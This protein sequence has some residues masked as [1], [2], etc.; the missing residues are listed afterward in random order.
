MRNLRIPRLR[1]QNVLSGLRKPR[2]PQ[3][4]SRKKGPPKSIHQRSNSSEPKRGSRTQ[5]NQSRRSPDHKSSRNKSA[6]NQCHRR[7]LR[8]LTPTPIAGRN[9]AAVPQQPS[10]PRRILAGKARE[11]I[12]VPGPVSGSPRRRGSFLPLII[13]KIQDQTKP[14]EIQ[15]FGDLRGQHKVAIHS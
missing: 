8:R 9:S 11:F 7:S 10:A 4:R 14:P 13:N 6:R 5:P 12:S 2:T 3:T 15:R 1:R